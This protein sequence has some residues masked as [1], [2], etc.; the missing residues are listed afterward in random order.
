M[1]SQTFT[2]AAVAIGGLLLGLA[3]LS[4][5]RLWLK[6]DVE[7]I[8]GGMVGT[9]AGALLGIILNSRIYRSIEKERSPFPCIR[10]SCRSFALWACN[11]ERQSRK[12]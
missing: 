4:L 2:V 6:L 1:F 7:R 12:R 9:L 3:T 11:W 10:S 5:I 8:I